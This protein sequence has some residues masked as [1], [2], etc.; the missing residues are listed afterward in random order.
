MYQ[1]SIQGEFPLWRQLK[2]CLQLPGTVP[3]LTTADRMQ[4]RP[5]PLLLL[6]LFSSHPSLVYLFLLLP[7]LPTSSSFSSLT[8]TSYLVLPL[9]SFSSFF[10]VLTREP[11][12]QLSFSNIRSRRTTF[13]LLSRWIRV[14]CSVQIKRRLE[15]GGLLALL[16]FRSVSIRI[17]ECE[18]VSWN[19]FDMI[20]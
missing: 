16:A 5:W 6:I 2:A 12:Q 10:F 14:S 13:V 15:K 3:L 20:R 11:F 4:D 7:L 19:F 18:M 17:L 8:S 1:H 9:S